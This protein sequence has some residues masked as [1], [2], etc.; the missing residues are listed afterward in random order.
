MRRAA[1]LIAMMSMAAAVPAARAANQVS[2]TATYEAHLLVKVADLR[3][4]QVV[5][6]TGFRLGARLTSIGALGVIKPTTVLVQ[7]N[8]GMSGGAVA[9]G[10]Y[11]QTEKNGAKHRVVRYTAPTP[12]DPLAGLL[13][14]ALQPGNGQPCIG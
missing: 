14:A 10:V 3:T 5:T 7:S 13:R 12:I 9:P 1:L 2:I 8:G 11:Q 6:P 4:D